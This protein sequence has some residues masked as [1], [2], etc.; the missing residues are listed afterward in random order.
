MVTLHL[1]VAFIW[2]KTSK[3]QE[4]GHLKIPVKTS[5]LKK[6]ILF[7]LQITGHVTDTPPKM[8]MG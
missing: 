6:I 8:F 7:N 3:R 5:N 2:H 1:S 4:M